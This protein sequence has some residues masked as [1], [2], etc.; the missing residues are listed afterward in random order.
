[1]VLAKT[2]LLINENFRTYNAYHKNISNSQLREK[3]NS[4]QQPLS[5][6]IDDLKQRYFL[7]LS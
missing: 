5:D 7:K 6:L 2:K 4:L 1:M 3:L